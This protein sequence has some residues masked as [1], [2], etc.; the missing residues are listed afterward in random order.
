[1]THKTDSCHI[2]C[3]GCERVSKSTLMVA[4]DLFERHFRLLLTKNSTYLKEISYAN[5]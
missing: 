1:M 3:F 5:N 4:K 2:Y